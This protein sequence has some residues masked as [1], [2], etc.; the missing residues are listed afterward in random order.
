MQTKLEQEI[1]SIENL[2]ENTKDNWTGIRR[3]ELEEKKAMEVERLEEL[4]ELANPTTR[5]I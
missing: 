5:N 3:K 4:R 1:S 2:L